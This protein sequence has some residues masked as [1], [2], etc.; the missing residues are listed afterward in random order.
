MKRFQRL[1][2]SGQYRGFVEWGWRV[3]DDAVRYREK[4]IARGRVSTILSYEDKNKR[5]KPTRPGTFT[6]IRRR[7][8]S[9]FVH[10]QSRG[11][12][13]SIFWSGEGLDEE[14][15]MIPR[16]PGREFEDDLDLGS[17]SFVV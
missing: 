9:S 12:F 8:E 1:R 10:D 13:G 4:R 11:T 5:K 7:P 3:R 14:F 16:R 17:V 15:F 6:C 2:V